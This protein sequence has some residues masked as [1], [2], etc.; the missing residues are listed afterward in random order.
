M[1]R[2]W[3]TEELAAYVKAGSPEGWEP[4]KFQPMVCT[5]PSPSCLLH[6]YPS[7]PKTRTEKRVT[8]GRCKR[9][10]VRDP[11]VGCAFDSLTEFRRWEW[12]IAQPDVV[13][14][15][16]HP[17]FDVQGERYHGDFLVWRRS[18][19]DDV[20]ADAVEEIKASEK[21]ARA[22][23]IRRMKRLFDAHHPLSPLRIVYWDNPNKAWKEAE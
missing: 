22:T 4:P 15:D 6:G 8:T 20:W 13:H 7:P 21:H 19:R 17:I 14:V 23:D 11:R 5:C 16:V 3:S 12:L 2:A 18:G 10:I 9:I 1:S